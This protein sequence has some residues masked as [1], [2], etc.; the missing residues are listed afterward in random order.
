MARMKAGGVYARST[1]GLHPQWAFR[2]LDGVPSVGVWPRTRDAWQ[3]RH[4]ARGCRMRLPHAAAQPPSAPPPTPRPSFATHTPPS[5]T[6]ISLKQVDRYMSTTGVQDR[7]KEP[8]PPHHTLPRGGPPR[9][10]P[11]YGTYPPPVRE[12]RPATRSP[13]GRLAPPCRRRS[14]PTGQ[15]KREDRV[16]GGG[17]R[18]LARTPT[19]MGKLL[20]T[21]ALGHVP[22]AAA[23]ARCTRY[24]VGQL[25]VCPTHS[26]MRHGCRPRGGRRKTL[27]PYDGTSERAPPSP[28]RACPPDRD[29]SSSRGPLTLPQHR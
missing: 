23:G 13:I 28:P 29:D 25:T 15:K 20:A 4:A 19:T 10:P 27:R 8:W 21:R 3:T 17:T 16:Q 12:G 14:C 22:P 26:R 7:Q 6:R 9:D 11:V 5:H 1:R 24:P 18:E 2:A